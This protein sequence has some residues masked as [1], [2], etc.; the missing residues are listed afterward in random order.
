MEIHKQEEGYFMPFSPSVANLITENI[1][2]L[3]VPELVVSK[4]QEVSY[5]SEPDNQAFRLATIEFN[6][7]SNSK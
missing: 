7:S 6:R 2:A 1:L 5:P 4:K 3:I